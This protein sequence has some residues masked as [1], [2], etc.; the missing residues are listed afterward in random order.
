[1]EY[2]V[3]LVGH[4]AWPAVVL[5][6]V[7]WLRREIGS[8]IDRLA[9]RIGSEGTDV[10]IGREGLQIRQRV[11]PADRARERLEAELRADPEFEARLTA[12]VRQKG[13]SISPTL[14]LYGDM[15]DSV[16]H[17]AAAELLR[18]GDEREDGGAGDAGA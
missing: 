9:T 17:A 1:M 2:V 12:W 16:R 10:T 4:L 13:L 7:W 11:A 5:V 6:G 18:P 14:L 15:Y 3:A 8:I